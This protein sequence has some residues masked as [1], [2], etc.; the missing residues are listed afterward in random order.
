MKI[1]IELPNW[2]NPYSTL[3]ILA[4]NELVAFKEPKGEWKVKKERCCQCGEC[5]FE[6]ECGYLKQE[7]DR[8]ICTMGS[9][10]PF[11]CLADPKEGEHESC[12][13]RYF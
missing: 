4:G 2:V 11:R 13:I 7:G 5:C 9:R 6:E 1:E 3:T 12:S 8:W 10:K